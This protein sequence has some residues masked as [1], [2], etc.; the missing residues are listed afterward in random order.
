MLKKVSKKGFTLIEILASIA[1]LAVVILLV[2]ISYSKIR[3]NVLNKQYDNLKTLVEEVAI[4]YSA[5]TGAYNFFVQD[6]IDENYLEPDDE[7]NIYDPRDKRSINCRLV[8][9]SDED[10][11][12]ATLHEEDHIT[13]GHCDSSDVEGYS[14]L[15][16]LNAKLSGTETVYTP[17]STVNSSTIYPYIYN[18]WTKENIDIT[19]DVSGITESLDNSYILWNNV[20]ENK[21][22]Y[23]SLNFTTDESVIYDDFYY[24]DLYLSNDTR[25]QARIKYK[26]DKEKPVIY[27]DKTA[28]AKSTSQD[29]WVKS[30]VIVLYATDKDGVGLDRIYVGPRPCTDLLTDSSIGQA[31]IPGLVQTYTFTGEA[32]EE[33]INA[34][35][36][37]VDKLG[38]L[39]DSG[40]ILIS[41][42]DSLPPN[43]TTDVFVYN[44]S[45]GSNYDSYTSRIGQVTNENVDI[46]SYH[47]STGGWT[48]TG[49]YYKFT[50]NDGYGIGLQ[51]GDVALFYSNSSENYTL[52]N[53]LSNITPIRAHSSS[54]ESRKYYG[55]WISE[56]GRRIGVFEV[57][58]RLQNCRTIR[59]NN[60]D[61]DKDGPGKP[62]TSSTYFVYANSTKYTSGWTNQTLYAAHAGGSTDQ[63]SGV[64]YYQISLDG[65]NSTFINYNYNNSTSSTSPYIVNQEGSVKRYF[66]AVDKV[67][68]VGQALK[69]EG[70]I[71]RT[72]P[73]APTEAATYLVY[74]NS[75]KYTGGWT[76][77]DLYA[78]HVG[79]STDSGGSGVSYYEISPDG[80]ES[81]FVTHNY[82][83][84]TRLTS[85]HKVEYQGTN[86]R[87]FRAVDGA[88]NR[89]PALRIYGS[90]DKTK[91][92]TTVTAYKY[93]EG[94]NNGGTRLSNPE[95]FTTDGT[96]TVSSSEYPY[97][98]TF[99]FDVDDGLSGIKDA[100]WYWEEQNNTSAYPAL[101]TVTNGGS[102]KITSSG[103]FYTYLS[104]NGYRIGKVVVTDNG[105]NTN[106]VYVK[107]RINNKPT[108]Q[109]EVVSVTSSAGD[110]QNGWYRGNIRLRLV[111]TPISGGAAIKKLEFHC[112]NIDKPWETSSNNEYVIDS[113]T[114]PYGREMFG[115]V[116][117]N[118]GNVGT[119]QANF[120]KDVIPP[121]IQATANGTTYNMITWTKAATPSNEVTFTKNA[122]TVKSG[123]TVTFTCSDTITEPV[124]GYPYY[125]GFQKLR[126]RVNS[127]SYTSFSDND[128]FSVTFTSNSTV[129]VDC[130]DIAGN[131]TFKT[132]NINV[133]SS[134]SG[135][136]SGGSSSSSCS[137]ACYVSF[138]TTSA[139][140]CSSGHVE[141]IDNFCAN[142]RFGCQEWSAWNENAVSGTTSLSNWEG[143]SS[144]GLY[145]STGW[146]SNLNIN[147]VNKYFPGMYPVS[148]TSTTSCKFTSWSGPFY[149]YNTY[150]DP[151]VDRFR[152]EVRT[153][154]KYKNG[155]QW[156]DSLG[157]GSSSF[158]RMVCC[159]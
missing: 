17:T 25:Y 33:G 12:N 76:N 125:S 114:Q 75:T 124:A 112:C 109:F 68:N 81:T 154:R 127:G 66:R 115:R 61:I 137:D 111:G 11:I 60:E 79:G 1:I 41:K 19:P 39:A 92:T 128:S 67:G 44:D 133:G 48:N 8:T 151:K 58:D 21:T 142:A 6:L 9:I 87:Y 106:T 152:V 91:P 53:I 145:K 82:N 84:V 43:V 116:T 130:Y 24:A 15:L 97:P 138:V 14:S 155:K 159:G 119:C 23:P 104:S 88:G 158:A 22:Y 117:D 85:P 103:T 143:S 157:S 72:P 141:P 77:E 50:V 131:E 147:N 18:G 59:I 63:G 7:N 69:V 10:P 107:V 146:P 35:V 65:A 100:K 99:Q 29:K 121:K 20:P 40:S 73:T 36:C 31:A 55:A 102:A 71:D 156:M 2:T 101:S 108:C 129:D 28:I 89:G 16:T 38:N 136:S 122:L 118:N 98:V 134:N 49:H 86:S 83:S 148:C 74:G 140:G 149:D 139:S 32:S 120:A 123:T 26:M 144:G 93:V 110:G 54:T 45:Y 4:K 126:Y 96:Y 95:N 37:A 105:G 78:A 113:E 153:C 46:S 90:I 132:L 57:C 62:S 34:N 47:S 80:A 42:V 70:S 64:S 13:N 5:K 27:H 135:S 30:R 52:S 150:Y 3:K 56:K 51:E 94:G